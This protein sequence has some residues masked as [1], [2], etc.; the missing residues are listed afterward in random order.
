M[1]IALASPCIASILDEGLEKIKRFLSEAS[2]RGA[3]RVFS[4]SLSPGFAR[5]GFC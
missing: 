1:I 2:A 5:T 3:D 4:G